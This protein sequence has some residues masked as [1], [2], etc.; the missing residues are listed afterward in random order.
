WVA[1]SFFLDK[2]RSKKSD[3]ILYKLFRTTSKTCTE[4]K[5]K[6][7][8]NFLERLQNLV[9]KIKRKSCTNFLERLQNLVQ[10]I[11]GKSCTNFLEQLQN[12]VQQ[13]KMK[14]CTNFLEQLQNL[15]QINTDNE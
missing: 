11:K 13:M 6:S 5:E 10:K 4:N 7:C 2:K 12:L 8:T 14:S 3:E 9:Q 15:V 1:S